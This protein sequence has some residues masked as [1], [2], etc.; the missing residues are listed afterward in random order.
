MILR[1]CHAVGLVA[2]LSVVSPLDAVPQTPAGP[3]LGQRLPGSTPEAFAQ[4]IV[5]TSGVQEYGITFSPDG[6]DVFFTREGTILHSHDD[7]VGWSPPERAWFDADV[8]DHEPHIVADGTRLFWGSRR[9]QPGNPDPRPYGIWMMERVPEGWSEPRLVGPG[10]QVS[11]SRDGTLYVTHHESGNGYLSRVTLVDGR[12]STYD[13]LEDGIETLRP[14]YRNIAHPAIAPDESFI[15][16]DVEGGR[17]LFVS[18]KEPDGRWGVPI[19]LTGHGF[20]PDDGIASIS[21]DGR[22]LFF[23]RGRD[24]A[25]DIYWVSTSVLDA[26]RPK[27]SGTPPRPS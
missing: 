19:D 12:F 7:G 16:F 4:G 18:F 2:L 17:H 20:L 23:A 27:G 1:S 8:L 6:K 24:A 10:T 11:S 5:S 25:R 9:K 22:Y 26:L 3:Y 13:H 14:R 21:P 15:V